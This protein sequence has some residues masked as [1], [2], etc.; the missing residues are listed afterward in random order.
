[1]LVVLLFEVVSHG[2]GGSGVSLLELAGLG[3]HVET[4]VGH[5][6]SFVVSIAS[7]H[8]CALKLIDNGFMELYLLW[9]LVGVAGPPLSK[10]V[11]L[12]VD[13]LEAVVDGKI[14]GYVV[15]DEVEASLEYPR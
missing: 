11:H 5:L 15:N 9:W 14:L 10:P 7:H 6:V 13:E 2:D 12:L 1:L 8:N 3:A 4:Y